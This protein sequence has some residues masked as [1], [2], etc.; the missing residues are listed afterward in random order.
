MP[1]ASPSA[2]PAAPLF[3]PFSWHRPD[4]PPSHQKALAEYTHDVGNGLAALL[5]LLEFHESQELDDAPLLAA[6]DKGALLRLA[7]ASSKLLGCYAYVQISKAN[8]AQRKAIV[9]ER[10]DEENGP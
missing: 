3:R 8:R 6:V 5:A 1:D 10:R 2:D 7:I 4:V 9:T